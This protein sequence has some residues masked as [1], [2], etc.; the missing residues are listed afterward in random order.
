MKINLRSRKEM[1]GPTK[2]RQ[3]MAEKV[4]VGNNVG[5]V[6]LRPL[7]PVVVG[8]GV[9]RRKKRPNENSL[10]V[11]IALLGLSKHMFR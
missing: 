7:R 8:V 6:G 4:V 1:A 5:G 3:V 9:G 2:K 11:L 10:A